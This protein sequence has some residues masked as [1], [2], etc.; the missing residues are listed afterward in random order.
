MFS[1][2]GFQP[3]PKLCES[4]MENSF[5][6]YAYLR[7]DG[8]PYYI[9]KG[10]GRRA[11]HHHGGFIS[12]PSQDRILF[13]KKNLSEE[14]AFK[15]EVYMISLY[16]RKEF[17]GGILYNLDPG[18]PGSRSMTGKS[19]SEESREKISKSNKGKIKGIPKSQEHRKKISD[20]L[21]GRKGK[22][23]SPETRQKLSEVAK[24][25]KRQPCSEETKKKISETKKA[26]SLEKHRE[27]V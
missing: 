13:L 6:T 17:E 18:G 22:P 25:R 10:K 12:P 7:K 9:G 26:K 21:K 5:Y 8:T 24:L 20:S 16:G 11:F 27:E 4:F 15:H 3:S 2:Q 19:H 1:S 23:H 14:E